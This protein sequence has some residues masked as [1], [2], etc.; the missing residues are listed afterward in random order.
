MN[1][2]STRFVMS[3]DGRFWDTQ[4]HRLVLDAQKRSSKDK[5]VNTID[6]DCVPVTF[7]DVH[8][9]FMANQI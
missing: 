2:Y 4:M 6:K 7:E 5:N 1:K 8:S 3:K 9:T